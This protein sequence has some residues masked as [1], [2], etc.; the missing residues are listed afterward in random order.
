MRRLSDLHRPARDL[1]VRLYELVRLVPRAAVVA[2]VAS[3]LLV[4]AHWA[5]PL[6]V[7][8]GQ[9]ASL[10]RAVHL[11]ALGLRDIAALFELAVEEL[12]VLRVQGCRGAREVIEG[13]VEAF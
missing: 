8:V 4:T 12:G 13:D 7:T 11:F 1:G 6:D 3:R 5:R 10:R 2:L 9:E